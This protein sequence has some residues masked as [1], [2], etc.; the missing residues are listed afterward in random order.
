LNDPNAEKRGA[1]EKEERV[2]STE[3]GCW[4]RTRSD[5]SAG[6]LVYAVYIHTVEGQVRINR[7]SGNYDGGA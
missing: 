4:Q 3:E 2:G 6:V 7:A 5:D 1:E